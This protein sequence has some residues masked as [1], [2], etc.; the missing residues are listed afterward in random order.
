MCFMSQRT[1]I[2][3]VDVQGASVYLGLSSE[4]VEQ[5]SRD[6]ARVMRWLCDGWRY[7]FN[8]LRSRRYVLNRNHE[9]IP[10]SECADMRSVK[11][12]RL[13]CSWI[14]AMPAMI[15]QSPERIENTQWF[16]AI[17]RR[18]TNIAHHRKAGRLPSFLSR[19]RDDMTFACW[20]NKGRNAN[21]RQV[22]RNHGIV[23]I[24]GQNP[25]GHRIDGVRFT[26]RI[27]VRAS[28]PIRDYT[29]VRINWTKRTLSFTNAPLPIRH[30]PTNNT[31]GIDMG[32]VHAATQSDGRF[33]DLPKKKLDR[34]DKEI[35]RRQ[36]AMAR[37]ANLSG[38]PRKQYVK[39]GASNRY[40]IEREQ[41]R[42]L[43][44]KRHRIIT[45]TY[46]KY[47]ASLIRDNDLI[48]IEALQVANMT[49]KAQPKPDPNHQ[50]RYLPNGQASKRGLNR[51]MHRTGIGLLRKMLE[52]KTQLTPDCTLVQVNPAYTSQTCNQCKHCAKENRKSQAVF[53]CAKC[54]HTDNADINAALNILEAGMQHAG[55]TDGASHEP[56]IQDVPPAQCGRHA[57]VSCK[58]QHL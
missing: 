40:G 46:Q 1:V 11:D 48:A 14:A 41:V 55:S 49:R 45:D 29:A 51:V 50:G 39:D 34:I 5:Y 15:V 47:S 44:A 7:R 16:S 57:M 21:Y 31:V 24:K 9:R 27:H 13:E 18:K 32:T 52:Y 6:G 37:K 25:Q 23:E 54:G 12:M 26:I 33:I 20:H 36:R 3:R 38:K 56:T 30:N 2:E 43:Y 22:N 8:A 4:G 42:R 10:L 19:K 17:A 35:R 28:Q 58:P 53:Q